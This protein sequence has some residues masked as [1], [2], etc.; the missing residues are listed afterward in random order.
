ML[1]LG[2][3]HIIYKESD[4]SSPPQSFVVNGTHILATTYVCNGTLNGVSVTETGTAYLVSKGNDSLYTFGKGSLV[5]KGVMGTSIYTFQA[6]GH[7]HQ[8]GKLYDIGIVFGPN[9]TGRLPFFL[10][11]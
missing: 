9:L 6:V 2:N 5:S 11:L 1:V 8:D 10:I 3:L 7:Y 4:K